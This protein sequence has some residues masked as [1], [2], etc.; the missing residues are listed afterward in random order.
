[1]DPF[2]L[3]APATDH[4]SW[5]ARY[6]S[7]HRRGRHALRDFA[8]RRR[9]RWLRRRALATP[10][11]TP[12]VIKLDG[13]TVHYNDLLALYIEYK[14]IFGWRLYDFRPR[15]E[16]PRIIDGGSH[17]GV[18]TLR[19]KRLAPTARVIAIEP[20]PAAVALLNANLRA[21]RLRDVTVVPA[22]LAAHAGE[23]AFQP[24][25][26][27]GGSLAEAGVASVATVPLSDYLHEPVE[28]LKLNIEGAEWPVLRA[29]APLLHNVRQLAIEYHGFAECGQHLH[30]ILMLLDEAGFRYVLHHFDYEANGSLRPPFHIDPQTRFF[31]LIAARRVWERR[32]AAP[33]EPAQAG[34]EPASRIFGFDRG[35]PIDRYYI[36]AFLRCWQPDIRG[37]ALEIGDPA[38]LRR[39]GDGRVTH[40]DVLNPQPGPGTTVVADLTTG[41]GIP[42]EAYDCVI[43]TQ[44]LNVLFDVRAALHTVHRVLKPGGVLLVTVP[45]I[46]QVS[47][48]D[49]DRWGEYWR[50]TPQCLRRLLEERFTQ[51]TVTAYGNLR[52]ATA[53][54]DGR[55]AEELEP[56]VLD[57]ADPDYPV[58]V[59]ARAVK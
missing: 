27:D 51:T 26:A 37:H 3:E 48:H 23:R 59:A 17:V 15:S 44:T 24:D 2:Q 41:A 1:M 58:T 52:V 20:D 53:F 57:Y 32:R 54:L 30:D 35:L 19:F 43:L 29:A 40:A 21:N 45:A 10:R 46:S 47:R 12:G 13:L 25:G 18:S 36:H 34:L 39:F 22:A 42:S 7:L 9:L 11:R 4:A 5:R 31:T 56:G 6:W 8:L 38:Y 14:H 33:R 50:F 28:F 16:A 55:A 49:A